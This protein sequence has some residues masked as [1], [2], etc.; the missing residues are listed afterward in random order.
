[1]AVVLSQPGDRYVQ[2]E[3]LQHLVNDAHPPLPAVSNNEIGQ[4]GPLLLQAA[5]TPED[6]LAHRSVIV[7]A[8]HGL[9]VEMTILLACGFSVA[10]HHARVYR[11]GPLQIGVVEA[12]DVPRLAVEAQFLLQGIHQPLGISFGIFDFEVLELLGAVDTGALLRVFEQ[13]ELF[14]AL[15]HREG[16][17]VEQ[18]RRRRQERYDDLTGSVPA[19]C[20]T[21]CWMASV[22]MSRS[23]PPTPVLSFT[24]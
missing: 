7:G 14:V 6:D 18:Q 17:T 11:M 10:E 3:I 19:I 12:F 15:G 24:V 21:T 20:S 4:L 22:S 13:F 16:H 23:S 5:V 9:D 8:L 2:P 1:M